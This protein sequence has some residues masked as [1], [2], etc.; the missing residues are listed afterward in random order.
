MGK[1]IAETELLVI[2]EAGQPCAA[3]ETGQL[4]HSGP[5][6]AMGYWND[7]QKTA[8]VFRPHPFDTHSPHRAVHSGDLVRRDAGGRLFFIGRND[9]MMKNHGFRV[10]PDEIEEIVHRSGLV[11]EVVARLEPDNAQGTQLVID[12]VPIGAGAFDI[13]PLVAFCRREMPRYMIPNQV[14]VHEY[15]PRTPSGKVDRAGLS[16]R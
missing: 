16:A 7:P 6:V 2:N 15:M 10:S 14:Y 9:Q 8:A 11:A 4:V 1:A 5:T 13:K 12:V 3:G